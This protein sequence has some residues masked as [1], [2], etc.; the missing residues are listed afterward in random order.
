[1]QTAGPSDAPAPPAEASVPMRFKLQRDWKCDELNNWYV[2][3]PRA[4]VRLE[5]PNRF[6]HLYRAVWL[7]EGFSPDPDDKNPPE[8]TPEEIAG[9]NALLRKM[10]QELPPAG[11]EIAAS[12]PTPATAQAASLAQLHMAPQVLA[13]V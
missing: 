7:G 6:W 5:L 2:A 10:R 3:I 12:P 4:R 13:F 9:I 8:Y 11:H 1:M